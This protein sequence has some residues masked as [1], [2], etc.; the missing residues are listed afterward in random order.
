MAECIRT[1]QNVAYKNEVTVTLTLNINMKLSFFLLPGVG[2]NGELPKSRV[3]IIFHI[4]RMAENKKHFIHF[5]NFY[6][7]LIHFY[8]K[9]I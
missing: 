9:K 8:K 3:P 4:F 7:P 1:W 5:A 2:Q 6:P